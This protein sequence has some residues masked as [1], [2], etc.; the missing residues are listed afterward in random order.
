MRRWGLVAAVA[1][2]TALGAAFAGARHGAL[3][4]QAAQ[5]RAESEAREADRAESAQLQVE[6]FGEGLM[7]RAATKIQAELQAGRAVEP[8]EI[9]SAEA[10][11]G[12]IGS[13]L[14]RGQV[15]VVSVEESTFRLKSSATC[16]VH[17]PWQGKTSTYGKH[18]TLSVEIT[19]DRIGDLSGR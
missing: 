13:E 16:E 10:P 5:Q 14:M 8:G 4:V 3:L 12:V 6:L 11:L 17:E 15:E 1:L 9:L 19:P 7:L 18:A 2:V